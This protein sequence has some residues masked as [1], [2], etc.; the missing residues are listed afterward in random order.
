MVQ[1]CT[2]RLLTPTCPHTQQHL[3]WRMIV[4]LLETYFFNFQVTMAYSG[5]NPTTVAVL[6]VC[7]HL[8]KELRSEAF[9]GIW[10][11]STHFSVPQVL[12]MWFNGALSAGHM[13]R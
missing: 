12:G 6:L 9:L 4:K 7:F 3:D 11:L 13:A 8:N 5:C 10:H 1:L 2:R